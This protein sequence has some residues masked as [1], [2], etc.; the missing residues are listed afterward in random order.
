MNESLQQLETKVENQG[1]TPQGKV[2]AAEWNVLVAAVKALDSAGINDESLKKYLQQ[3]QY[4]TRPE[5]SGILEDATPDLSGV[6]TTSGE[7]DIFG[8]KNFVN[9]LKLS[10]KLIR[11]DADKN[12]FIFPGN[13]LAEGGMAWNTKLEGFEE[14]TITAAVQVDWKTIGKNDNGELCVIGGTG[15]S[16]GSGGV[17]GG[18]TIDEVKNYLTNEGYATQ[19]WVNE[20]GFLKSITLSMVTSALGYTPFNAANFT[21]TNIKS[22][23]GIS[24]WALAS[25]KPSYAWTE[26]T[27]RPTKVSDFT[28]DS[29]FITSSSL[30]TKLSQ[31]TDDVVTGNYLPINATAANSSKL[32]GVGLA[33]GSG[34]NGIP[35][36]S[37]T[38]YMEVGIAMDFHRYDDGVD[39]STRLRVAN[40]N[41]GNI[42]WLPTSDGTIALT[43][44]ITN[45]L[46]SYVTIGTAQNI[47]GVKDFVNGFKIGGTHVTYNA[48]KNA[49]VFPANAIFEGGV[50]WNSSL[51][52]FEPQTVTDAVNVDGVTIGRTTS[53]A[54]TVLAGAGGG[55]NEAQLADY[56][57]NN[58]YAKK[59]DIPS[60]SG[61]ATEAFVTSRGYIT[62]AAI[63]T[64]VS[65]FDNDSGYITGITSTMVT[66]ALGYTPYNAANFTKANIKSTLG[67]SDWAL[68]SAKPTY[69]ASEVGALGVK[70][71][72]QQSYGLRHSTTPI[73]D[74][75]LHWW[76]GQFQVSTEPVSG[77]I[78]VGSSGDYTVI[79][80]PYIDGTPSLAN[81]CVLR[82]GYNR[83][84]FHEIFT[85]PNSNNIYH[86]NVYI[87]NGNPWRKFAF[88]TDIPTKLSQFTDDVV[89]GNYLPKDGIA[90]GAK[91]L[92]ALATSSSWTVAAG[93]GINCYNANATKRYWF[94]WSL[95]EG[96]PY[97]TSKWIFG[98][99]NQSSSADGEVFAKSLKLGFGSDLNTTSYALHTKGDARIDGALNINGKS[100]SYNVEK[101]A[102][103][104]SA[105]LVV[106][107][108]VAWN[109]KLEGFDQQTVTAAVNV[110]GTTITKTTS[111]ALQL[112]PTIAGRIAALEAR[113]EQLHPTDS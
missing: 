44:D 57:T 13:I 104:L 7:Q 81:A 33:N 60:L 94:G 31:L 110:D 82:L 47:T 55:I 78:Y 50:A 73:S 51:D 18:V 93:N 62:S 1:A 66:S 72:A 100:I 49:F 102:L 90:A 54:L 64:K 39:F 19:V 80:V 105:N 45:A 113:V 106:E 6:V 97:A 107:G 9:G 34:R 4:I 20:Q 95:P 27:S 53:G 75:G 25:A 108:G 3:H 69:T 26:I 101:N 84:F 59:S 56:L 37:E 5:L 15:D 103:V 61:Y 74:K 17:V 111:G 42:V 48:S 8:I 112:N 38:G 14:R 36:L 109:T 71:T 21:K 30:P 58:N 65:T 91:T 98:A 89:S 83:Q 28:N 12:V 85:S 76:S 10:N 52:G 32:L 41:F 77:K 68:A 96:S 86:R 16:P 29:G 92:K 22:T 67:I 43:S 99:S 88:T 40:G 2:S 79:S 11:Y 63:P 46:A 35:T 70:D 23:L 24:D 87:G